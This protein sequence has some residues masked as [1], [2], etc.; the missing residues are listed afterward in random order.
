MLICRI[1]QIFNATVERIVERIGKAFIDGLAQ[2]ATESADL[3]D[4]VVNRFFK[5]TLDLSTRAL[6]LAFV[7]LQHSQRVTT[8]QFHH[9]ARGIHIGFAKGF[10]DELHALGVAVELLVT[11]VHFLHHHQRITARAVAIEK[12]HAGGFGCVFHVFGIGKDA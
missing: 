10:I 7:L 1:H 4:G 6:D 11:G 3:I 5:V 8:E 9:A 12:L 2:C